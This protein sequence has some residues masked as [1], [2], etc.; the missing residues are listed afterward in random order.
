MPSETE[1]EKIPST[2][3]FAP[4]CVMIPSPPWLVGM[5]KIMVTVSPSEKTVSPGAQ[6][7]GETGPLSRRAA[8]CSGCVP[9]SVQS[10]EQCSRAT[11]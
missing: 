5:S 4:A 2:T 10:R 8:S 1:K 11:L 3:D 7:V 9:R 6:R